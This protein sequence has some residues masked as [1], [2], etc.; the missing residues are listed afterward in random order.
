[1]V[2]EAVFSGFEHLLTRRRHLVAKTKAENTLARCCLSFYR[3]LR[4]A[5]LDKVMRAQDPA[6]TE[7]RHRGDKSGAGSASNDNDN[8]WTHVGRKG[9][10][11]EQKGGELQQHTAVVPADV[12]V[13]AGGR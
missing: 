6:N 3:Y 12:G 9:H 11:D 7:A 2:D 4:L 13:S 1:M 5:A 10:G 8:A